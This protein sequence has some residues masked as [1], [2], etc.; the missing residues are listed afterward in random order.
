MSSPLNRITETVSFLQSKISFKPDV[1]M[2]LGSGLGG[3]VN[4][5][6]VKFSIDYSEVPNFPVTTV[7]G[8]GGKL[9]MGVLNGRN[10]VV[11]QGR[12]HYYEGYSMEEVTFPSGVNAGLVLLST[13]Q[14]YRRYQKEF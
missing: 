11:M 8:H 1:A 4:H 13:F 14:F 3:L 12:F 9:V 6:D 7:K 2:V 5:I 10:V